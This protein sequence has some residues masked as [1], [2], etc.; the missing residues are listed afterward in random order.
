MQSIMNC[1]FVLKLITMK[2]T[3]QLKPLLQIYFAI[4]GLVLL[5]NPIHLHSQNFVWAT[6]QEIDY[7]FNPEMLNYVT[8]VNPAGDVYYAGLK[9]YANNYNLEAFGD[10]FFAKYDRYG[11]QKFFK[12]FS[13]DCIVK[14]ITSDLDN[15]IYVVGSLRSDVTF[16]PGQTM[17]FYESGSANTFIIKYSQWG[18]FIWMK[19]LT[20]I[21]GFSNRINGL[22]TDV[23]NNVYVAYADNAN[24]STIIRKFSAD[25]D[26]LLEI[27]QTSVPLVSS[28][29][30]SLN[31]DIFVAGSCPT[32][33]ATFGG[34][35][36]NSGFS[37]ASYVAKY[38][39]LGQSQWVKFV[40]DVTCIEPQVKWSPAGDIYLSGQLT[41]AHNFGAIPANGPEWVY[42]F[43]LA[44]M[45]SEGE[46]TWVREVPQVLTGDASV[47]K[48]THLDLDFFG[49]PY[50]TGFIRNDIS[51]DDTWQTSVTSRGLIVLAYT[52]D[53]D[54][55]WVKAASGALDAQ[56]IS[57][58]SPDEIYITGTAFGVVQLDDINLTANSFYFPYLAKIEA[59][60][61]GTISR[62]A[63]NSSV[64]IYPNPMRSHANI[65]VENSMALIN[66]VEVLDMSGNTIKQ[67]NNVN[68]EKITLQRDGMSDGI[69][70]IRINLSDGS[71][72]SKKLVVIE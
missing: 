56:A 38:N 54:Y 18:D 36:Y 52:S 35:P 61:T 71:K 31:G 13:G 44:Q 15:Y 28:I 65:Q 33:N 3:T 50:I 69:Y 27:V 23:N 30:V 21:Y 62:D 20:E 8:T 26:E 34:V 45:N 7:D 53:G 72:V 58:F 64:G 66:E 11:E 70:F 14:N 57:V 17:E 37:Y 67:F 59:V 1:I 5:L 16:S 4:L 55:R 43:F 22:S 6:S 41:S 10:N 9:T 46:F 2:K 60:T 40:E 48:L 24:A 12:I 39:A 32:S 49:N 51:W 29:D 25:G 42:D 47:G 68:N 19:N 63:F